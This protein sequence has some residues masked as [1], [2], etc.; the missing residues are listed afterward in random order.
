MRCGHDDDGANS[1]LLAHAAQPSMR[2]AL[3]ESGDLLTPCSRCVAPTF[4]D[5]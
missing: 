1:T 3:Q 5:P 4:S 2:P